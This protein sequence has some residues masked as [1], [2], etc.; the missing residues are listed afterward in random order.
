[1]PKEM[2]DAA[3]KEK[4]GSILGPF[5]RPQGFVVLRVDERFEAGQPTFE[6]VKEQIQE[7]MARP[8]MEPKIRE[9]LTRLREE[10]FLEIKD[11]YVDSGAAPGKDT[12]WHD[13]AQLKPQTTTKEEVAA[14]V[15]R[16]KK[17]L[18]I[19]IPGTTKKASAKETSP[20]IPT[21]PPGPDQNGAPV[22]AQPIK[23]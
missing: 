8:K 10:A 20:D 12:R 19:P 3:F 2:E 5:K 16:H 14:R 21:P 18:F 6:E 13:V 17:V 15:H 4:K 1:M 23:K 9:F 7:I 11:G 22:V